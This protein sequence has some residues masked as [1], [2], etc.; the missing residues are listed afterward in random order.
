[1]VKLNVNLADRSYPIYISPDFSGLGKAMSSA[2]LGG[3][4]MIVTDSNVG[5]Y[6]LDVCTRE[7]A[8]DGAEVFSHVFEAGEKSKNLDTVK[9]IYRQLM[10]RRFDRSSSLVALG[11]GVTGDSRNRGSPEQPSRT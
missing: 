4:V 6:Y 11:G 5:K 7:L 2:R 1:M 10:D 8:A 9:D 3:K